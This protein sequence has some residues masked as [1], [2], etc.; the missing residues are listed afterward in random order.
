[1][2]LIGSLISN[3]K[4]AVATIPEKVRFASAADAEG[5]WLLVRSGP[6]SRAS[7]IRWKEIGCRQRKGRSDTETVPISLS[8]F[9]IRQKLPP[10][11]SVSYYFVRPYG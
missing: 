3:E 11:N 2:R 1:M 10:N 8:V 5:L 4:P 7:R 6:F 9:E